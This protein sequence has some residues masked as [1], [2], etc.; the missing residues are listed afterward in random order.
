M[1]PPEGDLF[2]LHGE[3]REAEPP[4][5]LSYT[6]IWEPS[7]PD[8]RETLATIDLTDRGERTEVAFTQGEFATEERLELHRG[9]WSD[10]FDR[11]EELLS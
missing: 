2:H 4:S 11:L 6:F 5:H 3:F 8:D 10:S 7:N 1:Q 9:G